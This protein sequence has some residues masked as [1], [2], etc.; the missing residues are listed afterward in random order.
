MSDILTEIKEKAKSLALENAVKFKG[1]ANPGA[2]IGPLMKMVEGFNPKVLYPY[3][4]GSS[5]V[6]DLVELLDH[7]KDCEIRI[8]N[9]E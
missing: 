2:V 9:L 5:N 3:H 1:R 6:N 7:K 8:R 4:F